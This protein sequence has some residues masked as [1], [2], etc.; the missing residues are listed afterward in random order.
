MILYRQL[1]VYCLLLVLTF[2]VTTFFYFHTRSDWIAFYQGE[3]AFRQGEFLRAILLYQESIVMGVKT[4]KAYFHLG[5]ALSAIQ[6]FDEA[7]ELYQ[8]YLEQHPFDHEARLRYARVLSYKGQLEES[9]K[10]YRRVLEEPKNESD[11]S[12]NRD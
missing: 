8:G 6:K 7:A 4:R 1:G 5:D 12:A 11:H 9:A 3:K 10:E 2:A